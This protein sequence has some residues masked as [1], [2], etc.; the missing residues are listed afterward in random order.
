MK[1][2]GQNRHEH[3]DKYVPLLPPPP[4]IGKIEARA[5]PTGTGNGTIHIR[6]D[7]FNNG[8][9]RIGLYVL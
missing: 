4:G 2:L 9:D 6:L 1:E 7:R 3:V 8:N 5:L